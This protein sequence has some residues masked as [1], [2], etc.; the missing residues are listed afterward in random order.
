M[1]VEMEIKKKNRKNYEKRN[2]NECTE[3]HRKI[4]K[5]WKTEENLKI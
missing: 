2:E 4:N 1:I 3:A 5:S